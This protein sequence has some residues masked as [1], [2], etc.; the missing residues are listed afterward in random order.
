M[1]GGTWSPTSKP[2]LPGLYARFEAA[3]L[4]SIQPGQRGVVAVVGT[5]EWG[6]NDEF[7]SIRRASDIERNFG[8]DPGGDSLHLHLTLALLGNP[9]E[10][11]AYRI[12]HGDGVV[13]TKTLQ[14]TA[15][16]PANVLKLDCKYVG[17]EGNEFAVTTRQT[18]GQTSTHRDLLLYWNGELLKTWTYAIADGIGDL[19]SQINADADNVWVDA[20]ELN[21]GGND[22]LAEVTSSAF[23]SGDNGGAVTSDDYAAY[24]DALELEETVEAFTMGTISDDA[25]L[26][27]AQA[28]A[29]QV[30]NEG[31]YIVGVVGDNS[32]SALATAKALAASLDHESMIVVANGGILAGTTYTPAQTASYVAGAMVGQQLSESLTYHATPFTDVATRYSRSE[33]EDAVQ[34]GCLA[35][36]NDGQIVKIEKG[37]N[38]LITLRT[39]Q[40]NKWRKIRTIRIMDAWS[41]DIQRTAENAYIG[42]IINDDDGRSALIGAIKAYMRV[43]VQGRLAEDSAQFPLVVQLDPTYYGANA[44]LDPEPDEAYVQIGCRITDTIDYCFLTVKV[45]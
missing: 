20:T 19:V 25:I 29:V 28:W 6:P 27:A 1:A 43:Q 7:V 14:D 4:A 45:Q 24:Q 2:V 37:I 44:T 13:G 30:R 35:L 33:R 41:T 39:G 3:A 40:D 5:A 42:K 8:P 32:S 18:P 31:R 21:A 9:R 15:G 17:A 12:T 26:V 16:S 38:S 34:N 22:T 36:V 11:K 23:A 10:I